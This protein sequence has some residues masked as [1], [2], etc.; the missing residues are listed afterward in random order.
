VT[1]SS[2][3][4]KPVAITFLAMHCYHSM[5]TLPIL[6]NLQQKYAAQG[7]AFLPIFVN[8]TV[9]DVQE[10]LRSSDIDFP[11]GAAPDKA[12]SNLFSSRMVPS[13]FLI[14]SEGFV[15]QKLVG[16]KSADVMDDALA[17]LAGLDA[18]AARVGE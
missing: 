4:G 8:T 13:M 5:D 17:G 11:F 3:R 10:L 14:D 2:L 15:T 7:I 12:I 18:D 16:F 6:K 1:L 9:E